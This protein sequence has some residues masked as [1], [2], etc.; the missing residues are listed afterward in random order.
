M[1]V[2]TATL[3]KN[4]SAAIAVLSAPTVIGPLI[5]LFIEKDSYV[6]SYALQ[7]LIGFLLFVLIQWSIG[8]VS[9]AAPFYMGK[10]SGLV[11]IGAFVLYLVMAY[12]A[13]E[14]KA[15][16]VPIL[17]EFVRKLLKSA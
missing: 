14:G 9:F 17:G 13:W 6:R 16:E 4:I 10:L 8:L 15:W 3:D 7:G 5:F 2:Q 12:K 1:A 11:T